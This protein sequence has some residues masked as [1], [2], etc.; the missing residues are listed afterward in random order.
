MLSFRRTS[1]IAAVTAFS[2]AAGAALPSHAWGAREQGLLA[3]VLGTLLVGAIIVDSTRPAPPKAQ[4]LPVY[5]PAGGSITATPAAAE[6][7]AYSDSTQRRIQSTLSAFGY[8]HGP[9][10]GTFG[11][12]TYKAVLA[13]ARARGNTDLLATRAGARTLYEQLLY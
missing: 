11:P 13:Y 8:Y 7:A 2:L 4:P 12:Q 3:G 1:T 10:D 6:F 5:A 9:I